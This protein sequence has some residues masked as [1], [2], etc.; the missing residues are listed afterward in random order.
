MSTAPRQQ[1]RRR[2]PQQRMAAIERK[3]AAASPVARLELVQRQIDLQQK[4]EAEQQPIKPRRLQPMTWGENFKRAY[5][6]ARKDNNDTYD[7]IAERVSRLRNKTSQ[8]TIM[9]VG[10]IKDIDKATTGQQDMAFMALYAMGFDPADFGLNKS[11]T[12]PLV[13]D[14]PHL[15]TLRDPSSRRKIGA[16]YT[17]FH[18]DHPTSG[19]NFRPISATRS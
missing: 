13:Y 7:R 6:Q 11:N 8:T 17:D 2:S 10:D 5:Y 16:F 9:R 12:S 15:D 18:R 19:K 14:N 4:I 3:I 1:R